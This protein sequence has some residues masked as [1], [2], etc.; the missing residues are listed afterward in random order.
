[1][2][3]KGNGKSWP[4]CVHSAQPSQLSHSL[5]GFQIRQLLCGARQHPPAQGNTAV[6]SFCQAF[7][8]S[9]QHLSFLWQHGATPRQYHRLP[10]SWKSSFPHLCLM[11]SGTSPSGPSHAFLSLLFCSW[12]SKRRNDLIP[13][14]QICRFSFLE[15]EILAHVWYAIPPPSVTPLEQTLGWST[16]HWASHCYHHLWQL[17]FSSIMLILSGLKKIFLSLPI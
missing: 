9:T 5:A 16:C 1:M 13:I 3:R 6:F 15:L 14:L 10:H 2:K 4:C 12:T 11:L 8:R 17:L 7:C